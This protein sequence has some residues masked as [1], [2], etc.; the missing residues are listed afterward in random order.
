MK[1]AF[2]YPGQG[3]QAI[4]MGV[5]A[6]ERFPEAAAVFD[7]ASDAVGY[8]M[9]ALC[10]EGPIEK[11]SQTL[12]TQPALFTVAAAL[13][14][15]LLAQ[16]VEPMCAA[17]HSLGE[18]G[19]WYAAEVFAFEDGLVL[20]SERG[21]LMDEADPDG[22]GT[23]AAVIGLEQVTVEAACATVDGMVVLAN[24]NAPGQVIISGEKSAVE[25]AGTLCKERGAKRVLPLKVSGAFHSPLMGA[26]SE[27]FAEAVD[28]CSLNNA[29]V[30]VYANVTGCPVT[31][32][33]EIA[34]L[35]VEQ[36]TSPVQWIDTIAAMA[37]DGVAR[38]LEIGPGAVLAGLQRRM[39][40][41]FPVVSVSDADTVE[42]V[43]D[44]T[45]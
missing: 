29:A 4:G 36:L 44:A 6:A 43:A 16:G 33:D 40:N 24:I 30:P 26:A 7:L 1:Q 5:L 9:L 12:Y 34:Q 28:E 41:G 18:Y 25:A 11:L 10:T 31:D 39:E 3:A 35:M 13:T 14:D 17:G 15:S 27:E 23:M 22:I 42:E 45:S 2:I 20:V 37:S 32:A 21:R 38:A 19:A 8:D